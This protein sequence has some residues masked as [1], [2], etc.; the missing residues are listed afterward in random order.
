VADTLLAR[1]ILLLAVALDLALIVLVVGW[2]LA[3]GMTLMHLLLG[4]ALALPLLAPIHG[5]WRGNRRTFAWTTL[6]VILYFVIGI[7]EAVAQ[8]GSRAWSAPC[9]LL[10][11]ALFVTLIGYLRVTRN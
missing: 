3:I 1:R 5:L 10:A 9:L 7:T 4:I 2:Q 11:L 8:P 6:C